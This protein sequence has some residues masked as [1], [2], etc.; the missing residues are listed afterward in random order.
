MVCNSVFSIILDME[1]LI[2]ANHTILF[3]YN[4]SLTAFRHNN[5]RNIFGCETGMN[6]VALPLYQTTNF[7]IVQ[8]ESILRPEPKQRKKKVTFEGCSIFSF[9]HNVFERLFTQEH[10]K[11]S[12]CVKWI[13][14][15][16]SI[17]V[18]K[19]VKLGI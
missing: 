14:E 13:R 11:L 17:P 3:P 5:S 12:F 8:I 6:S 19:F 9:P 15:Q 16:S 7:R 2:P 1:F 18:N 10:Q 4:Y